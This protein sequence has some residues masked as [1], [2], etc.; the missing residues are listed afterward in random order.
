MY[1]IGRAQS[2]DL[3]DL[4]SATVIHTFYARGGTMQPRSLKHVVVSARAGSHGQPVLVMGY[5]SAGSGE[6]IVQV[7]MPEQESMEEGGVTPVIEAGRGHPWTRAREIV[8]RIE[9]PGVWE[10][11]PNGAV[12]GVRRTKPLTTLQSASSTT[13]TSS[14]AQGAFSTLRRRAGGAPITSL[15]LPKPAPYTKNTS[16]SDWEAYTYL[17]N[18]P[19]GKPDFTTRDLADEDEDSDTTPRAGNTPQHSPLLSTR[20]RTSFT[21]QLMISELGPI[22]RL[23]GVSV[24]VGFGNVIKIV[25]VGNEHFDAATGVGVG[26]LTAEGLVP[27]GLAGLGRGTV[28]RKK[29]GGH[30]YVVRGGRPPP[31]RGSGIGVGGE[32]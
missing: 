20:R 7:Y 11:M 16:S 3:V 15:A 18:R 13:T 17:F 22:I 28:R 27:P 32:G 2:V 9:N 6:L 30:G 5:V 4:D 23:S 24:A 10:L 19:D 31:G 29:A 21:Q 26:D 1:L 25:S 8:K 12:V 14:F